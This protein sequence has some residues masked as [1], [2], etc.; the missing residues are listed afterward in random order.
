MYIKD[1]NNLNQI[2]MV[3]NNKDLEDNVLLPNTGII[4]Y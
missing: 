2:I 1:R 3:S 4:Y